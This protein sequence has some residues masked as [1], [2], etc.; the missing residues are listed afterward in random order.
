[1]SE[2]LA[3]VTAGLAAVFVSLS[4]TRD[5]SS[6]SAAPILRSCAWML[7]MSIALVMTA[8][9]LESYWAPLVLDMFPDS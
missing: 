4:L 5:D 3:Y 7:V 6:A 9:A 1:M 2:A 8:A